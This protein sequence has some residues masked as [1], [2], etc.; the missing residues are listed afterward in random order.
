MLQETR[1][2]RLAQHSLQ[3]NFPITCTCGRFIQETAFEYDR[4]VEAGEEP[5]VVMKALKISN[6]CC[7]KTVLSPFNEP[8]RRKA[9]QGT[10]D[11]STLTLA[12]TSI[13]IY[14]P[15]RTE[16]Y[17]RTLA[18]TGISTVSFVT[19]PVPQVRQNSGSF[20]PSSERIIEPKTETDI[21]SLGRD[22]PE[23]L[24]FARN[25]EGNPINVYV[26][27]GRGV[28]YYVPVLSLAISTAEK[29]D[30]R[31]ITRVYKG[32]SE[33]IVTVKASESEVLEAL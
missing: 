19:D 25:N 26:G 21:V 23:V 6:I 18:D 13:P 5:V 3:I 22:S 28:K 15:G 12:N 32:P 1:A 24:G 16:Q 11:K 20:A 14:P 33:G 9:R 8:L 29:F 10:V 17:G 2:E 7:R 31:K 27:T 4:R 30:A